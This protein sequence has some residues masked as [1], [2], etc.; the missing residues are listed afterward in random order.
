MDIRQKCNKMWER[1]TVVRRI[2]RFFPVF[3]WLSNYKLE[4]L[5]HDIVAGLTVGMTLVPQAMAYVSLGNLRPEFGLYSAFAGQFIYFMMGTAKDA[6]IGPAAIV[7]MVTGHVSARVN[8]LYS[9]GDGTCA[10]I[11]AFFAG[12]TLFLVGVLQFSFIVNLFSIP[13]ISGFTTACGITI[14]ASQLAVTSRFHFVS[15]D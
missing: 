2:R 13:V 8:P 1:E 5:R 9:E 3:V 6:S 4:Y 7:S 10:T 14:A 11:L 15:L 12:I